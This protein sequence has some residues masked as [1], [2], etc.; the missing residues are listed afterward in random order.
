[1]DVKYS[2][3]GCGWLG[4]PLAKSLLN[5]G[6]KIKGST[7]SKNKLELLKQAGVDPYPV[8][9]SEDGVK[10]KIKDLLSGAEALILNVPPGLRKDPKANYVAKI[11]QLIKHIEK[12]GIKKVLFI[13]STSVYAD[14]NQV[15]TANSLPK[16]ETKSGQ[17]LLEVEQ[18]LQNNVN[19]KT[20]I[21]RFAGLIGDGRHPVKF[22]SGRTGLKNPAAPVNLIHLT[23]CIGIIKAILERDVWNV[24]FNAAYPS[25]PTKKEYYTK[26]ARLHDLTLPIFEENGFSHGKTISSE[27]LMGVLDYQF[28]GG[29]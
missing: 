7:T 11:A 22:L 3:L 4:F 2:V 23:D 8:S 27:Q 5:D 16:P 18:L 17:Q 24:V 29:I 13:G 12:S 14:D 26:Q 1:M 6:C 15:V 9:L 21:L 20:T 28:K 10:G 19:F 25:H